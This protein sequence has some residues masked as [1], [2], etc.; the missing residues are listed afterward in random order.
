MGIARE[1]VERGNMCGGFIVAIVKRIE[2][3]AEEVKVWL[4]L[5]GT[6]S[7]TLPGVVSRQ[8]L[9]NGEEELVIQAIG[10]GSISST[11]QMVSSG[12]AGHWRG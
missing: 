9:V 8:L 5:V 10:M 11:G 1:L 12:E 4:S 6:A 3:V 7:N 2:I